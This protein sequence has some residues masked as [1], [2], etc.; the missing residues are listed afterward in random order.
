[1]SSSQL[2][3]ISSIHPSTNGLETVLC[4]INNKIQYA[5]IIMT[6]GDYFLMIGL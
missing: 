2:Q 1:M 3:I 4:V 6:L 5:S